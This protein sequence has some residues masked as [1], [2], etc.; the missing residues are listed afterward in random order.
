MRL[1]KQR[2]DHNHYIL[3]FSIHQKQRNDCWSQKYNDFKDFHSNKS[4]KNLRSIFAFNNVS[5]IAEFLYN[6]GGFFLWPYALTGSVVFTQI[7][8]K[9]VNFIFFLIISHIIGFLFHHKF[10]LII[11]IV[12]MLFSNSFFFFRVSFRFFSFFFHF[13]FFVFLNIN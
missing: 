7:C 8:C 12:L 4:R 13:F 3:K 9:N 2:I 1:K 11:S 5:K 6:I 10:T